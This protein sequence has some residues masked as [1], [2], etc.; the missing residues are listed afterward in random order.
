MTLAWNKNIKRLLHDQSY[1]SLHASAE[2]FDDTL[3]VKAQIESVR[4][5]T[6]HLRVTQRDFPFTMPLIQVIDDIN[7]PIVHKVAGSKN[8]VCVNFVKADDWSPG[9][10]LGG[11]LLALPFD[12]FDQ[13]MIT[14]AGCACDGSCLVS[15]KLSS[16]SSKL[17]HKRG[18]A[19][20]DK[21]TVDE[22][23]RF[24]PGTLL[25]LPQTTQEF[26]DQIL[27]L[28]VE[29]KQ[30]LCQHLPA[31]SGAHA[32]N[33]HEIVSLALLSGF[34]DADLNAAGIST[35]QRNCW[36][37]VMAQLFPLQ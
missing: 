32:A 9:V 21:Q 28:S 37:R 19:S 23:V 20:V 27:C 17:S 26:L 8:M 34:E 14:F 30:Q 7:H 12:I 33:M 4:F 31:A 13:P 11:F 1:A 16:R 36:M 25:S 24:P 2:P 6:L 5:G 35:I 3:A 22:R 15:E 10:T 18:F 29:Q